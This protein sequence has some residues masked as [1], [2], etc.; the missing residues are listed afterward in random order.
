M[1]YNKL[2]EIPIRNY[3]K[4]C[5]GDLSALNNGVDNSE[6]ELILAFDIL[7][8]EKIDSFGLDEKAIE[9][10]ELETKSA[11][12]LADNQISNKNLTQYLHIE[13]ELK[14]IYNSIDVSHRIDS[15]A[16]IISSIYKASEFKVLLSPINNTAYDLLMIIKTLKDGKR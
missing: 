13:A 3:L 5:A 11:Q 12:A 7:M 15:E 14:D 8:D 6:E 10:L 2:T 9:I 4:A 16:D 1:I